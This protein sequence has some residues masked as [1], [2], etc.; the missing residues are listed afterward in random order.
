MHRRYAYDIVSALEYCVALHYTQSIFD[1]I[2]Y[3]VRW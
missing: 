1:A 2:D 3:R